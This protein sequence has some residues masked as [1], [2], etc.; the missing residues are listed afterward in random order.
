MADSITAI[1]VHKGEKG[2]RGDTGVCNLT[3][4][5][6]MF[7]AGNLTVGYLFVNQSILPGDENS[8]INF[9]GCTNFGG[10]LFVPPGTSIILGDNIGITTYFNTT[11]NTT[12]LRFIGDIIFDIPPPLVIPL[13]IPI[14]IGTGGLIG[15]S[16][17]GG[18][19]LS[20]TNTTG[21]IRLDSLGHGIYGTETFLDPISIATNLTFLPCNATLGCKDG[22]FFIDGNVFVDGNLN[23][24]NSTVTSNLTLQQG[25]VFPQGYI[26]PQSLPEQSCDLTIGESVCIP[27][28]VYL[29]T[30]NSLK[31]LN[32][33]GLLN[34]TNGQLIVANL[35]VLSNLNISGF[36]QFANIQVF[37]NA[38]IGNLLTAT[39]ALIS[40]LQVGAG[41]LSISG[42]GFSITGGSAVFGTT[43]TTSF[44]GNVIFNPG[45][46]KTLTC[47]MPIFTSDSYSS[48]HAGACI[49]ECLDFFRCASVRAIGIIGRNTLSIAENKTGIPM[50]DSPSR[51]GIGIQLDYI[52]TNASGVIE[53]VISSENVTVKSD[54]LELTSRTS[55]TLQSLNRTS[56]VSITDQRNTVFSPASCA[57]L[58]QY[59]NGTHTFSIPLIYNTTTTCSQVTDTLFFSNTTQRST[60][61]FLGSAVVKRTCQNY[62]TPLFEYFTKDFMFEELMLLYPG[63]YTRINFT[64][65]DDE[66]GIMIEYIYNT[67]LSQTNDVNLTIDI[68]DQV[69]LTPNDTFTLESFGYVNIS[70]EGEVKINSSSL[71]NLGDKIILEATGEVKIRGDILDENGD[72]HPCC[73]G[74]T[75]PAAKVKKTTFGGSV[76]L[77]L[78]G[79]TS[80]LAINWTAN[81]PQVSTGNLNRVIFNQPNSTF[82]LNGSAG[83]FEMNL[84]VEFNSTLLS[85]G[86][87]TDLG[88]IYKEFTASGVL[89][90]TYQSSFTFISTLL[91]TSSDRYMLHCRS[92]ATYFA[93]L[94]EALQIKIATKSPTTTLYTQGYSM[95]ILSGLVQITST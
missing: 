26:L 81:T 5:E 84:F 94:G 49:P 29:Q 44:A 9:Q 47:T 83:V 36:I 86:N 20:S 18:L 23:L 53:T 73:T 46:N 67:I 91:Q 24:T 39:N 19:Q 80:E 64:L 95:T 40:L 71:I 72:S 30:I 6:Q 87:I 16:P 45:V 15:I 50:D 12:Y 59:N 21:G 60:H 43:S 37:N 1:A 54:K 10:D 38:L 42:G 75:S 76:I 52:G 33:S 93:N 82:L 56:I 3:D 89:S 25:I 51:V 41:G 57:T 63:G 14:I 92:K 66:L 70:S 8:C 7:F 17:E 61:T 48:P 77:G 34:L 55:T 62:C 22:Q 85:S 32:A 65:S 31:F 69:F 13:D 2:D 4:P 28:N 79:D 58:L 90:F 74:V 68:L 35:T 78:S 11:T 27:G 88:C